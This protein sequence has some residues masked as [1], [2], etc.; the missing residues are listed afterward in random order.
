MTTTLATITERALDEHHH[1]LHEMK[2]LGAHRPSSDI[3]CMMCNSSASRASSCACHSCGVGYCSD[4]CRRS[5]FLHDKTCETF[6]A[7]AREERPSSNHYRATI[8]GTEEGEINFTWV[9]IK[10]Q[11]PA[12][13]RISIAGEASRKMEAYRRDILKVQAAQAKENRLL[14]SAGCPFQRV[15]RYETILYGLN[16]KAG[17]HNRDIGHGVFGC[18]PNHWNKTHTKVPLKWANKSLGITNPRGFKYQFAGPLVFLSYTYNDATGIQ[19]LDLSLRDLRTIAKSMLSHGRPNSN[20]SY[21]TEASQPYFELGLPLDGVNA[22]KISTTLPAFEA[23]SVPQLIR[24]RDTGSP[25]VPLDCKAFVEYFE[26]P[27][28]ECLDFMPMAAAYAVGLKWHVALPRSDVAPPFKWAVEMECPRELRALCEGVALEDAD[29][30][31]GDRLPEWRYES[32]GRFGGVILVMHA[33]GEK[34]DVHQVRALMHYAAVNPAYTW[35]RRDFEGFFQYYRALLRKRIMQGTMEPWEDCANPY[36]LE[37]PQF[38]NSDRYYI[39]DKKEV[40][41]SLDLLK[42]RMQRRL[43]ELPGVPPADLE[44]RR[45]F[46]TVSRVAM[47]WKYWMKR[48]AERLEEA[49]LPLTEDLLP[50]DYRD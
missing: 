42:A 38:M 4:N 1:V 13:A 12:S 45:M 5:D 33:T 14:H 6:Q 46:E 11:D 43:E 7:F 31:T 19:L 50:F 2:A 39:T 27:S 8:L 20:L 32:D 24:R 49:G 3:L 28:P 10:D 9:E 40:Y 25:L 18:F 26:M 17:L 21:A 34:I 44:G 37:Q 16:G 36:E 48:I 30:E 47:N 15:E 41:E 22:I 35:S 23:A 29:A